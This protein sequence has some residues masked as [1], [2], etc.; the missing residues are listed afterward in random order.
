MPSLSRDVVE[1]KIPIKPDK[2]LVKQTPRRFAP[3]IQSKI[4]EQIERL[5]K[6]SFIRT[7]RYVD[8]LANIVLVVKKNGILRVYIDFRNLNQATPKDE[9]PML[10]AKM[11]VESAAGYEYLG[12]LDGY[13]SYIQIYISEEDV[14]KTAFRCPG[15]LGCYEWIMMPFGLKNVGACC[16][17]A[18][19]SMFHD[20]I[21]K[22]MQF[23]IDDIV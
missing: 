19:N 1:L 11:L 14:L 17:R 13:S 8:W 5:L 12:I 20:F 10:V 23:Y 16:Q 15:A 2:K 7:A 9:Y 22:F 4:K 3:Q 6:C 18:M 21:G